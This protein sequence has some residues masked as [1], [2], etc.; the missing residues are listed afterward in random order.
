LTN[1]NTATFT[2]DSNGNVS[3]K[4]DAAGTTQYSWDFENRLKQVTLPNGRTVAY[5]YDALGRRVQRTPSV[6]ISTNFVYDGSD[7][8]KDLNSDGS[9]VDYVDGP[10]IDNKLRLTDS[11]LSGPLYFLQDHLGSTT[12][13]AN[14]LGA[15]VSQKSYDSFGNQSPGVTLTRY[16]YTG[17]EFDSDTGLYYYRARWYDPKLGRFISEDPIGLNG[18]LNMYTYAKSNPQNMRDPWGL[19]NEDVHY[20]LTYFI[21]RKFSCLNPDEARLIADADQS[22][23]ENPDTAPW[24]G[25]T[26]TQA[27]SNADNHAFTEWANSRLNELRHTALSNKHNYVGAGRHLHF[28]QDTYSHRAYQNMIIG[29]FG[30]NGVDFPFFGGFVVDN[31]DHDLAKSEE[32]ARATFFA[33]YEFAKNKDCKCKFADLR[34]WWPTVTEFLN[35]SN[36]DIERKRRILNV[37]K[38]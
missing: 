7:V 23:D 36:E 12:A 17:R 19:Y 11:R 31:T 1:T 33:L 16:G 18:G 14:S 22:T 10:G 20:Y 15:V 25:T 9:T 24:L 8:I 26:I 4:T 27:L 3:A 13:L 6:G 2:Y 28:L 38:R 35:A 29:Q 30:F 5:K 37:P 32:M 34:G 21:A